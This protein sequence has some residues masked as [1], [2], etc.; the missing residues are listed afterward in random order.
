MTETRWRSGRR[1]NGSH[2][3]A[4]RDLP[5]NAGKQGKPT[6]RTSCHH[7]A[8]AA[9]SSPL[10]PVPQAGR[11]REKGKGNALLLVR[12]SKARGE[13]R[14]R[15][16]LLGLR[17]SAKRE[18]SKA[19][20]AHPDGIWQRNSTV[21]NARSMS[22][23]STTKLRAS[24]ACTPI[25]KALGCVDVATWFAVAGE[26]RPKTVKDFGQKLLLPSVLTNQTEKQSRPV[27]ASASDFF[28]VRQRAGMMVADTDDDAVVFPTG[29]RTH[30]MMIMSLDPTVPRGIRSKLTQSELSSL[31]E[32]LGEGLQMIVPRDNQNM[33]EP[34]N[35]RVVAVHYHAIQGGLQFPP[36]P[37]TLAFLASYNIA[38]CQLTTNGHRFS[39]CFIT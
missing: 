14:Q 17:S 15:T 11:G 20:A 7:A 21:A 1:C 30:S 2:D 5:G 13:L 34:P 31:D 24:S 22:H 6:E 32:W 18:E 25:F 29:D 27:V 23:F 37:L 39:T 10:I 28:L 19:N 35:N 8:A 12:W 33:V 4:V 36:H 3:R 26:E 16:L 9:G 38:P